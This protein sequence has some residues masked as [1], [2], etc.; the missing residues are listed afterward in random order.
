MATYKEIQ[1]YVFERYSIKI[2]TCW[3]AH[4]KEKLGLKMRKAPN[5]VDENIRTN[6]CPDDKEKFIIEAFEYFKNNK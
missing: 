2:K 5:R 6:P 3:I 1:N 4:I